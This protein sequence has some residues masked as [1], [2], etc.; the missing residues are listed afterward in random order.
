MNLDLAI[1]R[2]YFSSLLHTAI[3]ASFLFFPL[4]TIR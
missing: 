3:N 1:A 4:A 2:A